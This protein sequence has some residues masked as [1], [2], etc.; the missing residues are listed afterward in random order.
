MAS[1]TIVELGVNP[2][3]LREKLVSF[4]GPFPARSVRVFRLL[5]HP[6]SSPNFSKLESWDLHETITDFLTRFTK[7][8]KDHTEKIEK[9]FDT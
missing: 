5:A 3:I 8:V 6:D 9:D 1:V 2:R 4:C 7:N